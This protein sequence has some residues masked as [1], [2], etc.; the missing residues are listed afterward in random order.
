MKTLKWIQIIAIAIIHIGAL[1]G[2]DML[3]PGIREGIRSY[4]ISLLSYMPYAVLG[5]IICIDA[6]VNVRTEA[7]AV[8]IVKVLQC[9]STL[10]SL[11][12]YAWISVIP[13]AIS[14]GYWL[15]LIVCWITKRYT[16]TR[17]R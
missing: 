17:L 7:M 10:A 14:L 13:V 11:F 12:L 4:W 16:H 9:V 15:C 2:L 3:L 8:I 1:L 6:R 5:V